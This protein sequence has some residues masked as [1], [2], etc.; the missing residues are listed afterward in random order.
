MLLCIFRGVFKYRR[1][2]NGNDD[3]I[4]IGICILFGITQDLTKPKKVGIINRYNKMNIVEVNKKYQCPIHCN[5]KHNHF[6]YYTNKVDN[7]QVMS[8]DKPKYK[9]LKKVYVMEE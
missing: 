8:I 2:K 4:I 5:I 1:T 9:K 3:L 6:V 7:K